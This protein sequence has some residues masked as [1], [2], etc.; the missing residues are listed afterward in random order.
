MLITKEVV[1]N[2]IKH[3]ATGSIMV[4]LDYSGV[5]LTIDVSDNGCGFEPDGDV[6][7][8]HYGLQGIRE[9]IKSLGGVVEIESALGFGTEILIKLNST[10]EW[11]V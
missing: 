3:A 6:A 8:G 5:G 9:R 11:E 10:A 7:I 1:T 4:E 2:A